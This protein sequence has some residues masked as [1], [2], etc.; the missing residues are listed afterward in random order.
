VKSGCS[1]VD[2]SSQDSLAMGADISISS[3]CGGREV[4]AII[5]GPSKPIM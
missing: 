5:S 3:V 1:V 4:D 2:D